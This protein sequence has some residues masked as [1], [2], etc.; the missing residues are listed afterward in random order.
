[1]QHS[2]L[3]ISILSLAYEVVVESQRGQITG[4]RTLNPKGMYLEAGSLL[5]GS[6]GT[7]MGS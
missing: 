1:M 4:V 6:L 3:Q 2:A 5:M 7:F